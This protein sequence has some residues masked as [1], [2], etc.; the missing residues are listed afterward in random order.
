MY[1]YFMNNPLGR[2]TVG[3]CS[4]RAISK[5]LGVSWDEAHDM[6]SDMSKNMGTIMNEQTLEDFKKLSPE[7]QDELIAFLTKLISYY[8]PSLGSIDLTENIN[9]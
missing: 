4:V 5:A 3:D 7:K 1:Q 6:L 9:Q 2:K 8:Q